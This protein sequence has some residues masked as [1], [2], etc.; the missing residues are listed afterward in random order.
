MEE[1][2]KYNKGYL[3]SWE[4]YVV[5]IQDENIEKAYEKAEFKNGELSG[6]SKDWTKTDDYLIRAKEYYTFK[7]GVLHAKLNDYRSTIYEK[8]G[9]SAS[10]IL[11]IASDKKVSYCAKDAHLTIDALGYF[12]K[13]FEF[14]KN[15]NLRYTQ[16]EADT[17]EDGMTAKKIFKANKDGKLTKCYIDATLDN[18]NQITSKKEIEL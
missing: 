14:G 6:F 8:D 11:S 5:V 10:S 16:V 15:N 1:R 9:F 12:G 13:Y 2:F 18:L 17:Q 7:D 3:S 4:T